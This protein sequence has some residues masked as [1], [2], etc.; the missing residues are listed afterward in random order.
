MRVSRDL[1]GENKEDLLLDTSGRIRPHVQEYFIFIIVQIH[2]VNATWKAQS[3]REQTRLSE[4]RFRKMPHQENKNR[5][6]FLPP[7]NFIF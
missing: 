2:F 7:Q 6:S 4:V 3:H 5:L 1:R